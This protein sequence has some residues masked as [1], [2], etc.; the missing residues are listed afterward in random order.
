[1]L[2]PALLSPHAETGQ[3]G[4]AAASTAGMRTAVIGQAAAGL[5]AAAAIVYGAGALTIALRLYFTHLS[6]EAVLGQLPRDLILTTGFGEIILPAMII[7]ILSA[8]LLNYLV[9][10]HHTG[11][12]SRVQLRLQRYLT[13]P[14]SVGHCL[15]WLLAS[16]CFGVLEA[17]A[18]LYFYRAHSRAFFSPKVVISAFDAMATAAVLSAIAVGIALILMPAP[19]RGGLKNGL[20]A[21]RPDE[22]GI[23]DAE[24]SNAIARLANAR[25]RSREWSMQPSAELVKGRRPSRIKRTTRKICKGAVRQVLVR[26]TPRPEPSS[27]GTAGWLALVATLVGFAAIPGVATFNAVT[28]FPDGAACS[29]ELTGGYLTGNLI[30]TSDGW[31][32][33]VEYSD[34]APGRDFIAMV[35]LSSLRLLAIGRSPDT[36]RPGICNVLTQTPTVTANKAGEITSSGATLNGQVDPGDQATTYQFDYGTTTSYGSSLPSPAGYAGSGTTTVNESASLTELQPGTTYHYRIE[37]T[38][39]TGTTY[40]PDQTLTTAQA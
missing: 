40:G 18:S 19:T 6:W 21:P 7:G 10:G 28:L 4:H 20:S 34:S 33:T 15:V 29:T 8:V 11:R 13:A 31:A 36:G 16:A 2:A 12:P 26:P 25:Q 27:L 17:L 37:A 9:N 22:A 39:A 23:G 24:S 14:P 35:P 38:N 5:T 30:A 32:Y 1:M 3:S